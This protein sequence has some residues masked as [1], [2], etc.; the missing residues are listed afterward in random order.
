MD[1]NPSRGMRNMTEGSPAGHIF[2]FALPLLAGSFLQQLYN[3]VDSWVVGNYVGDAALA[4]VGVGFPVIFMF[5]S[6]FIGLSNGGTVVIAQFYG[7]GRLD[8]VRDAVDTIYT[9]FTVSAVPITLLAVG[10]V[11]P[12]LLV[13]QVEEGA[14]AEAWLYL[15][16]VCAG[17]LG[18]IGYNLNAGILGGLGNSQTTLLFLAVSSVLNIVLDL[19][20]VLAFGLGVL[21]VALGTIISQAVSW[22]FGLG[23]IN[24]HY[25]DI[26]I[27]PFCRRFD[28]QLFR[29]IMGIG[30]PAG[31]QMSM[32]AIGSIAVM[33]KINSYGKE[34]TA[35]Y[36]VGSRLDQL[37]FLPV[38]SLSN[39]VTAFV[40]QN[41]GARRLD[42]ARQG[43]RVTVVSSVLWS[44]VMLVLIPLGPALVGLFTDTPAVI[45]A[46]TV[47][48]RCIMPF[49]VL[50]SVMFSLN[51]AMRGAGESV[52]PMVNVIFSLILLRVPAVYYLAD[53]FGPDYMYYGIGIGWVLGFLLSVGYYLSGRWKRHGSLAD[54]DS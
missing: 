9:A 44:A 49:Y 39:A 11:K 17:L 10:L 42:R 19:V 7:A 28:R 36:N 3:M 31:L 46:G 41:I 32:V 14:Y 37:A 20:L 16:V 13:L 22:L 40:G 53:R 48:L 43:I 15:T 51:N 1:R 45:E 27:R 33:S 25:P 12:L 52:F 5:S 21:G 35:A 26:A 30:L 47:Y 50:F 6:L 54:Q 24:R 38:Q 34:F 4:A 23:Y 18:T 29:Q 2:Y 8:R